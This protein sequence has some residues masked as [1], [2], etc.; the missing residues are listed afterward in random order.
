MSQADW[1]A[2]RYGP[3]AA[4]AIFQTEAEVPKGWEDHPSKVKEETAPKR[5]ETPPAKSTAPSPATA[6]TPSPAA[7]AEKIELDADG[8]PW[9]ENLHAATR[10]KTS[11][12]LWRMKV[13]VSRPAPKLDL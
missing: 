8:W 1:P 11:A 13:G 10:S 7:P 12:G 3:A 6:A 2:W 5:T 9:D 4:A